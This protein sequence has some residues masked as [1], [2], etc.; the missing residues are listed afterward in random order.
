MMFGAGSTVRSRPNNAARLARVAFFTLVALTGCAAFWNPYGNEAAP[1]RDAIPLYGDYKLWWQDT[2]NCSGLLGD[3]RRVRWYAMKGE[4]FEFQGFQLLGA[5]FPKRRVIVLALGSVLDSMVIRHE[6]LHLL[7]SPETH[8]PD[9][10]QRGACASL[11]ICHSNCLTD[12]TTSP[13][14]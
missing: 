6:I 10:Y 8:H 14:N 3:F 7:A 11:V 4:S 12:T 13:R 1:P 9:Y 2:E 5:A